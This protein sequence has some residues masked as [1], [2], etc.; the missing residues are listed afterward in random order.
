MRDAS[1]VVLDGEPRFDGAVL[2]RALSASGERIN[3]V[4]EFAEH[5]DKSGEVKARPVGKGI[6]LERDAL[7]SRFEQSGSDTSKAG[8]WLR[9]NPLNGQGIADGN[10]TACRFA[11]L[12]SDTLP[13]E[14]QLSLFARLPLPVA[15]ILSSGGRSVH[16]WVK[17]DARDV[18]E[19]R[20]GVSRLLGLLAK[21]GVDGKNKNPSRLSRL[22]GAVRVI[23]AAGDGVQRLL[24]LHP[25]PEERSIL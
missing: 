2:A 14:L 11:L 21:F 6:T 13:M 12:E 19:Y 20:A 18:A 5:A 25:Q 7:V 8:G 16:A 24:Y 15:A 23:G 9:M 10:V 1:A 17:L 22:P 3:F 4:T